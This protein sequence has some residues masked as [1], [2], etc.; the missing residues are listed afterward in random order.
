MIII[1][2]EISSMRNGIII[3]TRDSQNNEH[4]VSLFHPESNGIK[5]KFR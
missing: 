4:E 2:I 5:I 3:T 1:E